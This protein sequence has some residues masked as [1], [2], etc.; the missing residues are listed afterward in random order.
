MGALLTVFLQFLSRLFV[1]SKFFRVLF[2][3]GAMEILYV[4]FN[5]VVGFFIAYLTAKL[6]ELSLPSAVCWVF[7]KVD[8]F[9]L[10]SLVIS[11]L[12]SIAFA[13]YLLRM[14]EKLL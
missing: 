3:L 4:L 6:A 12:V 2:I 14:S 8:L 5:K 1:K 13:K 11:V 9:G 10:I 7:M